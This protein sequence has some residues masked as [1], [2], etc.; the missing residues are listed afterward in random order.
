MDALRLLHHPKFRHD[1]KT[2]VW[3]ED[4]MVLHK[5]MLLDGKFP[6][7]DMTNSAR[8]QQNLQEYGYHKNQWIMTSKLPWIKMDMRFGVLTNLLRP[9]VGFFRISWGEL[10][11]DAAETY[12]D[13]VSQSTSMPTLIWEKSREQSIF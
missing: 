5:D 11:L 7:Y 8:D 4:L 3:V 12:L 9:F 13:T 2:V 1:D 10:I 6:N